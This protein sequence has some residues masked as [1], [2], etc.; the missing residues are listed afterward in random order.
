MIL[1]VIFSQLFRLPHPPLRPLFYGSLM[2]ELCKTR[3]MPQAGF[4]SFFFFFFH[5]FFMLESDKEEF[6]LVAVFIRSK[7]VVFAETC[8]F[9]GNRSSSRT[10]LSA[11]RY[12]AT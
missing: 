8:T 9:L 10:V 1:E 5:D 7:L 4:S 2:I 12:N 3:D 6:W 11:N